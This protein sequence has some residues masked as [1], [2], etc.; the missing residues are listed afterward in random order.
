MYL[1]WGR[2]KAAESKCW[3]V[4]NNYAVVYSF[5]NLNKPVSI[6]LVSGVNLN[7]TI[8]YFADTFNFNRTVKV[9]SR[10]S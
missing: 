1:W 2:E 10:L 3:V 9:E 5:F 6:V 4:N 7:L 8:I